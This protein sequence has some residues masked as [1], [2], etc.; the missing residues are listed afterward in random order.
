VGTLALARA[1][2]TPRAGEVFGRQPPAENVP[3]ALVQQDLEGGNYRLRVVTAAPRCTWLV[4]E[5]LNSMS[6]NDLAPTAQPLRQRRD[7]RPSQ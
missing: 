5:V 2:W 6:S 4:E 3:T 7:G 1:R